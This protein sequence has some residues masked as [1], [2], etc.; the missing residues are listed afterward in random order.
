MVRNPLKHSV[1]ELTRTEIAAGLIYLPI[2]VF[3]LPLFMGIL[4]YV[5]PGTLTE[6]QASALYFLFGLFFV[7]IFFSRFLRDGLD[8]FLDNRIRSMPA[9][10]SA[11]FMAI[12]LSYAAMSAVFLLAGDYQNPDEA[13]AI[14]LAK[15]NLFAQIALT[16]LAGPVVEEVL[17]RG[18]VFGV[19]QPKSRIL[20]YVVSVLMFSIY[21]VWQM[22]VINPDPTVL[23][24]VLLDLPMAFALCWCYERGGSIWSPMLFHMISAGMAIYYLAA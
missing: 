22:F 1:Q 15:E 3:V 23:L 8:L 7:L 11:F 19:L 21:H 24:Y 6:M 20:A 14:L 5:S 2:H 12:L 16:A 10:V 17:F 13:A 18:V 9:I 4:D